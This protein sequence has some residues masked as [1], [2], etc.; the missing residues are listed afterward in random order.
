[1]NL[2][3]NKIFVS[4]EIKFLEDIFPLHSLQKSLSFI[5]NYLPILL[6]DNF[7]H[8]SHFPQI[9]GDPVTNSSSETIPP[10]PSLR[11]STRISHPPSYLQDYICNHVSSSDI[12]HHCDHTI[13]NLC[14][15][16]DHPIHNTSI[17]DIHLQ[18]LA[19]NVTNHLFEPTFYHQAKGDPN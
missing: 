14:I 5:D 19:F 3:I 9:H 6:D 17:V 8:E 15:G 12:C 1:M 2:T 7:N 16:I 13:S 10:L 18:H 4:R 11:R